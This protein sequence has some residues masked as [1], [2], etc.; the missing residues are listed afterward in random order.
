[1]ASYRLVGESG[2]RSVSPELVSQEKDREFY[3]IPIPTYPQGTRGEIEYFI[4]LKLGGQ[5]SR[6]NGIK[7]IR[8]E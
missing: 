3:K 6:I 4:D 1:M 2:Y 5:P 7:K 8:I